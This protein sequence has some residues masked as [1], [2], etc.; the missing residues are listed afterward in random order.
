MTINNE[1]EREVSKEEALKLAKENNW[2]YFE[3]SC[4]DNI[5]IAEFYIDLIS[6]IIKI[7]R[8]KNK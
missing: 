8:E 2:R 4:K 6:E 5:G 3:T 7:K 1:I